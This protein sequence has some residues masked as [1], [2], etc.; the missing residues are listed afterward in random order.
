M[1]RVKTVLFHCLFGGCVI[2]TRPSL[3]PVSPLACAYHWPVQGFSQTRLTVAAGA[4]PRAMQKR[5]E[6]MRGLWGMWLE[7]FSMIL[8]DGDIAPTSE[9]MVCLL[10]VLTR[11]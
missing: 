5:R 8:E 1:R 10:A 7:I 11:M 9:N 4:R 2:G 3:L 6:R